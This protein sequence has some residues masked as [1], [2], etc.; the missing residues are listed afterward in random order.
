MKIDKQYRV[1]IPASL[2]NCLGIA[3]SSTLKI[4]YLEDQ[5]RLFPENLPGTEMVEFHALARLDHRHRICIGK[6][7]IKKANLVDKELSVSAIGKTIII[8]W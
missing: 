8:R 1:L 5:V 2:C 4:T 7:F 3:P 6:S